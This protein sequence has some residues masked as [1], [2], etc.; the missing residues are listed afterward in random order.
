M[1]KRLALKLHPT[2]LALQQLY[3]IIT[4]KGVMCNWAEFVNGQIHEELDVRKRQER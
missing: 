4:S 1:C 2:Y 3:A